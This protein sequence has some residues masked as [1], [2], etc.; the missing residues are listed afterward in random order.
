M[1]LGYQLQ[2]RK[3]IDYD[4]WFPQGAGRPFR[5]PRADLKAADAIACIGAAQTFGR[6]VADP[7]P[8]QLARLT[9]RPVWNFGLS[10]AGPGIYLDTPWLIET[11]ARA[12]TIIVQAMSARSISA[13]LFEAQ[14][15]QG[16]LR[17]VAGP[18]AGRVFLAHEAY[19][20]LRER[21][22]PTAHLAQVEA[23]RARWVE[24]K[25]KLYDRLPGRKILLWLSERTPGAAEDYDASP[26]GTFPHFVTAQ[27]IGALKA[28][29]YEAIE[30]VRPFRM[31]VLRSDTTGLLEHAF[32][33]D[34][35]P[36]R[37]D[38]SRGINTYYAPP[39]LH[40]AATAALLPVLR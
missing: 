4:L 2:D 31:Q 32:Q 1:G 24:L 27:M 7:Y 20:R 9:G 14:A 19:G 33:K 3:I 5:G 8:A 18:D 6:F 35:F 21:D 30:V 36:G 15:N 10:G 38:W 29:G 23:V 22:G 40:D 37:P 13:G 11:L 34:R 28:H 17:E 12:D 39:D 26:V 25:K 16:V